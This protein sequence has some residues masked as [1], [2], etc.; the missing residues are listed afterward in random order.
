MD[1]CRDSACRV[2]AEAEAEEL[3]CGVALCGEYPAEERRRTSCDGIGGGG[4]GI[5]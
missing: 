5:P 2:S 4:G 1:E 3:D